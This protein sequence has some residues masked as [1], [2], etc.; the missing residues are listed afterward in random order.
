MTSGLTQTHPSCVTQTGEIGI[1]SSQGRSGPG[2]QGLEAHVS[3][4]FFT[5]W[6]Q[7]EDLRRCVS[8]L[9]SKCIISEAQECHVYSTS[10]EE[11]QISVKKTADCGLVRQSVDVRQ[12]LSS[13]LMG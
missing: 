11:S 12:T 5:T 3:G 7:Q 13:S 8:D 4:M 9:R 6:V 1:L 10:F 2:A